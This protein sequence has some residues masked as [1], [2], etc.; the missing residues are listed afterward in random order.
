MAPSTR[1]ALALVLTLVATPAA[2]QLVDRPAA[3]CQDQIGQGGG[4]LKKAIT[5]AARKCYEGL[6]KGN[7]CDLAA[8]D[9]K[10]NAAVA[11]YGIRVRRSC[12]PAVLFSPPP[13][14]L[15]FS[16]TCALE[17]GTLEPAEQACAALP[18]TD[19][20][21]LAGCLACWKLAELNE[22]FKIGYPCVSGQVPDGSDLD[23]GT[24]PASCPTASND[25]NCILKVAKIAERF[26]L[27]KEAALEK[28]L[29]K[30]IRGM[31]PGPCPD[32][33]A[34]A[35]IAKFQLRVGATAQHC[36]ALPPW[37]DVCPEVCSLP[38]STTTDM[39]NCVATAT[40]L[41]TDE[42]VCFQFPSAATNGITCPPPD[43]P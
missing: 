41:I 40:E 15:G 12:G 33:K 8:R 14:G 36:A 34:Q 22:L 17:T 5:G 29:S 6:V 20:Q 7:P 3:R 13:A 9:A 42:L 24:P 35:V 38:I 18:V 30:V 1:A 11:H 21:T 32:A 2:A 23:C 27:A 39:G 43:E 19:G 26:L 37:W 28:C 31:I 25:I 10:I 16:G 4:K